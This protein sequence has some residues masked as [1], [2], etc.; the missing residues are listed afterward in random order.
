MHHIPY[1]KDA[2]RLDVSVTDCANIAAVTS[3][4]KLITNISQ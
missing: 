2:R 1:G 4:M 3:P